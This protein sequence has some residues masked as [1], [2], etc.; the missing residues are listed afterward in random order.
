MSSL[1]VSFLKSFLVLLHAFR[2]DRSFTSPLKRTI[3]RSQHHFQ[4]FFAP[5]TP[6]LMSTRW[7]DERC[8]DDAGAATATGGGNACHAAAAG[9][10]LLFKSSIATCRLDRQLQC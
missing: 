2:L 5:K 7:P 3:R 6:P 1:Q 8:D 9:R 10:A 4:Y